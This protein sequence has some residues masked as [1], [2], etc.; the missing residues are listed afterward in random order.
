MSPRPMVRAAAVDAHGYILNQYVSQRA[1]GAD[2]PAQPWAVYLADTERRYWLLAFDL[3]AKSADSAVAAARDAATLVR[4]LHDV[5]LDA[6]VCES[7]PAGGR[8]VWTA[9]AE[10]IDAETVAT[11]ARLARHL[12]PTLDI[13]PLSNPATGCVRPPGSPHRSGGSSTVLTGDTRALTS[14]TGTKAQ[15]ISLVEH[16]AQLVTN[17]EP[18]R[19]LDHHQPLPVDEHGRLYLPGPRRPLPAASAAA[20]REDAASGDA[21]A[22]LWRVL[23]GAASARWHYT[24]IAALV[25]E[26]GLEHVRTWRD[27]GTRR[28]RSRTDAERVLRRQWDKAVRHVATSGRQVGDDP[29]FDARADAIASHVRHIQTRA[30]ASPGR[31][32]RGGG[33]ADRRILDALCILALHALRVSVEADIRRLALMTGIGRETARTALHRLAADSWISLAQE[34]A[35]VHAAT[36]SIDPTGAFHRDTD[37]ARSQADPRPEGAGAAERTTLLTTL[38]QRLDDCAHDL[39]TTSPGMGPQAGN[40]YARTTPESQDLVA[41]T[42]ATG[43]DTRSTLRLLDRLTEAGVLLRTR[44]GWKRPARDR[45]STAARHRGVQ[46]RLAARTRTYRVER[47][48]WAWWQAEET[49]MRAPGRL[50]PRRRPSPGQLALLPE[51]STSTWG[52]HPRR[53]DG[54]ADYRAARAIIEGNRT[55]PMATVDGPSA[56]PQ[57]AA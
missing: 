23:L 38:T 27:R 37:T 51:M 54:R 43:A 53:A 35:G 12:C 13:A 56:R 18:A 40:L 22:V 16:L 8:H 49:W 14:P 31:W 50:S 3:D 7:G 15:V 32:T 47:E 34:A 36:W 9:L 29:T 25:D 28:P 45:R 24:D 11:L 10:S 1:V 4:L 21:S 6:V 44:S 5:G 2:A 20:L 26:P 17:A 41:L 55:N 52:A 57:A 19:T 30:D 48:L 46:G 33:P 42:Q 39:F